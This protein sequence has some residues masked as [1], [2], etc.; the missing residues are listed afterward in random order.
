MQKS[1]SWAAYRSSAS[2]EIHRI[3]WDP[4]V[5]HR[6]HKSPLPELDSYIPWNPSPSNSNESD[7][8][9]FMTD[10]WHD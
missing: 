5:H 10:S 6:I 9:A 2:Q 4:K 3:L 7:C 8:E 1:P